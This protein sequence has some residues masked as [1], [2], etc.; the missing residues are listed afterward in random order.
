V[1]IQQGYADPTVSSGALQTGSTLAEFA[2]DGQ[3]RR[4]T[5]STYLGGILD[6]T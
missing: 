2:Y 6:N 1:K 5:E 4:T 3:N